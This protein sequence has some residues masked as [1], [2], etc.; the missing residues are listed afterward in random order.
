MDM[1]RL[2]RYDHQGRGSSISTTGPSISSF[3]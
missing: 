2:R 3:T 1:A